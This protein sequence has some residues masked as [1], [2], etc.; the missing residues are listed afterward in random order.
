M[1]FTKRT[2]AW[3]CLDSTA[4]TFLLR[5]FKCQKFTVCLRCLLNINS[6][7]SF[8]ESLDWWKIYRIIG[9]IWYSEFLEYITCLQHPINCAVT[10]MPL[11]QQTCSLGWANRF[12]IL[13]TV[14]CALLFEPVAQAA[15]LSPTIQLATCSF[16]HPTPPTPSLNYSQSSRGCSRDEKKG[17][18]AEFTS[19]IWAGPPEQTIDVRTGSR[20]LALSGHVPRGSGGEYLANYYIQWCVIIMMHPQS[21]LSHWPFPLTFW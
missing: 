13:I 16:S 7:E 9:L 3:I 14:G 18:Q 6:V 4:I 19:R 8:T 11:R 21:Q 15:P 2:N 5:I 10:D 20:M 1:K 17:I 12:L